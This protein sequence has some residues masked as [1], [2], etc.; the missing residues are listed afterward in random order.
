MKT[1]HW[2]AWRKPQGGF[3]KINFDGSKSLQGAAG[4]FIIRT[5]DEKFIQALAFNLGAS[6]VLIVEAMGNG[7][8]AVVQVGYTNIHIEGD[9][10]VFI[11]TVQGRNHPP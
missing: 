5:W 8:Q 2:V 4:G 11:H 10:K 1:T 3:I 6:S 7:L 9:N